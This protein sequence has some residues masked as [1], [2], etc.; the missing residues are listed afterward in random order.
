M[1][2]FTCGIIKTEMELS[3][4]H[5]GLVLSDTEQSH[6][7]QLLYNEIKHPRLTESL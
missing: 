2:Q 6:Y 1:P 4:Q 7:A 5:W 3:S